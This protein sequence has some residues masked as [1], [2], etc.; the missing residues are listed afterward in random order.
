MQRRCSRSM[1][2]VASGEKQPL[3][4]A[5]MATAQG[6][7]ITQS[8]VSLLRCNV[9]PQINWHRT[10]IG[11]N[12][13]DYQEKVVKFNEMIADCVMYPTACDI[14]DAANAIAAEGELV[15]PA[16]LAAISP[17]ITSTA[18]AKKTEPGWKR[19]R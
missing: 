11:H 9:V 15:D 6:R 14:T 7:F 2:Q 3:A 16:D 5:S 19:A 13:P 10:L 18:G 1:A 17:C 4:S 8:E 12:D